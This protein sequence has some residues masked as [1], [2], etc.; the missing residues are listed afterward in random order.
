MPL[1]ISLQGPQHFFRC[2]HTSA[3]PPR[4][5]RTHHQNRMVKLQPMRGLSRI[6]LDV[7]IQIYGFLFSGQCYHM[8]APEQGCNH[9]KDTKVVDLAI[10]RGSKAIGEDVMEVF[11]GKHTLEI[12]VESLGRRRLQLSPSHPAAAFLKNINL[13][14][15]AY[16]YPE[17]FAGTALYLGS[18]TRI[19]FANI[20]SSGTSK[21]TCY[22][23][24]E[25]GKWMEKYRFK[26]AILDDIR[27][28]IMFKDVI[29]EDTEQQN[30]RESY[31]SGGD[32]CATLVS[33]GTQLSD[34][35]SVP[36]EEITPAC[37]SACFGF[38]QCCIDGRP[39]LLRDISLS[40]T[41]GQTC[42]KRRKRGFS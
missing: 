4:R 37:F 29:I 28:M 42:S 36:E 9:S 40:R 12:Y 17:G 35:L 10:L 2:K 13:H 3:V 34:W 11:H 5:S 41:P 38:W 32:P 23:S 31:Y 25:A 39:S 27:A 22:V 18:A 1:K 19:S 7:R 20:C 8:P 21:D 26:Q 15:E 30:V 16:S 24:L 6:M 33:E 14:I